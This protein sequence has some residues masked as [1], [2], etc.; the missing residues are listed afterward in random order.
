MNLIFKLRIAGSRAVALYGSASPLSLAGF[1]VGSQLLRI[2]SLVF[3]FRTSGTGNRS[4]D[5][6]AKEFVLPD[7]I[8]G[9]LIFT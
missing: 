5:L 4:N 3:L 2:L 9:L 6:T 1:A 7:L 8:I